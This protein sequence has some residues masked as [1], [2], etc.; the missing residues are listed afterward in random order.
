MPHRPRALVVEDERCS[1]RAA[2]LVLSRAGYHVFIQG[3]ALGARCAWAPGRFRLLLVDVNIPERHA[4]PETEGN[5]L[6]FAE[7]V[8]RLDPAARIVVWS[9]SEDPG[10]PLRAERLGVDFVRK[11]DGALD[12]VRELAER[13]WTRAD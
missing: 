2:H 10:V 5:G 12:R 4:E 8:A 9:A 3:S 7:T 6:A 13:Y 1:A 11:D